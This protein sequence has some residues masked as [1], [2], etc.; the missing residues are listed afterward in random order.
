MTS[1]DSETLAQNA[2]TPAWWTPRR[3]K[4]AGLCGLVG[5]VGGLLVSLAGFGLVGFSLDDTGIGLTSRTVIIF[6]PLLHILLAVSL[7]AADASYGS[8][9]GRRGRTV[10]RLLVLSLCGEAV[11]ILV[12]MM[13]PSMLG[14]LLIPIGI[15]HAAIYMAIRLFGSLYGLSLRRHESSSRL[16]V[17]LFIVLFPS[18]FVL[19]PLTQIGFPSAFIGAPLDLAFIALS[20]ELWTTDTDAIGSENSVIG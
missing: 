4:L 11:T 16:T 2:G 5:G 10:A 20:Y 3:R 6:L 13:G 9:Y 8:S 15:L 17:G 1:G 18:I 7:F 14:G 12:L 19:A